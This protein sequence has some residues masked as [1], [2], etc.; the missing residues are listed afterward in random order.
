MDAKMWVRNTETKLLEVKE[1][2]AD[3]QLALLRIADPVATNLVQG[4]SNNTLVG[5][6]FMV[7]VPMA[8]ETGRFPAFGKEAFV[9]RGDLKRAVGG[10]VATL[11][12]QNGYVTMSLDEYALGV[13]LENREKN[14]WAGSPDMLLTAKLNQTAD[15]ILL[16]KEYLQATA[17]TTYTNYASGH[18]QSGAA[19]KWA[20]TGDP[21][22]DIQ[23]YIQIP[24]EKANGRGPNKIGFNPT[25]WRLFK[26]NSAVLNRIKYG[27]S[28]ISPAQMTT[29]AA[30]DLL[31]VD[32]VFVCKAVEGYSGALGADGAPKKSALTGR[33]IWE[34]ANS[35]AVFGV[36]SGS[37]SG[38]EPAFGY[39]W[40]RMNSPVVE[41]YYK[42]ETKSQRWDFEYFFNAAVTLNTAGG[43]IYSI[44]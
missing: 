34:K 42:N 39:T 22:V 32:E 38:I 12:T 9:L 10:K 15:S 44:A 6:K 26:N 13:E 5:D 8:K 24:V 41:S 31:E 36:I 2:A 18:Y 33:Y 3:S 40:T 35:S 20:D 17:L 25:S 1:F 29:K 16:Y 19:L 23:N 28:P 21:I 37:G 14:E 11:Q 30:A 4:Y 27:G 43:I 7:P